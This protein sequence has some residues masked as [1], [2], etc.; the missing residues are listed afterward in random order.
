M[1]KLNE[2]EK[3]RQQAMENLLNCVYDCARMKDQ[4]AM[5]IKN[6]PGRS[7]ELCTVLDELSGTLQEIVERSCEYRAINYYR[8]GKRGAI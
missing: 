5:E 8:L 1:E 4:C 2:I 6:Q 7:A 3:L